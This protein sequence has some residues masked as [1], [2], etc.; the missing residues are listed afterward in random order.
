MKPNTAQ[1]SVSNV[2]SKSTLQSGKM[3]NFPL[4]DTVLLGLFTLVP[5][6]FHHQLA[7]P[8]DK[9]AIKRAGP[10]LMGPRLG[11]SPVRS[12]TQC[13]ARRTGTDEFYTLKVRIL[14]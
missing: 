1:S 9:H 10:Y 5:H 11:S 7:I 4:A 13:L 3:E 6:W 8:V 2:L 12:I 14:K